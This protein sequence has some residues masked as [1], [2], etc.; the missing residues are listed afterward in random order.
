MHWDT[1]RAM[2]IWLYSGYPGGYLLE[3]SSA[4]KHLGALANNRLAMSQQGVLVAKKTNHILGCVKRS[5]DS[6]LKEVII[7]LYSA[8]VRPH[9][10]HYVQRGFP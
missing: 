2:R 7:L 1:S 3:K 8:T 6:R 4:E 9:L 10:E 5:V